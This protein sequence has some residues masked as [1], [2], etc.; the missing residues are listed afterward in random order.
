MPC[1][2]RNLCPTLTGLVFV[3]VGLSVGACGVK[4]AP[5][6]PTGSGF[7]MAYPQLE[8]LPSAGEEGVDR[9]L[10]PRSRSGSSS[11]IYQYPNLPSYKPP[12]D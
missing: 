5:Q 8:K 6:H 4:S 3:F 2:P 7:P 10:V 12:K 9:R 1:I 11:G